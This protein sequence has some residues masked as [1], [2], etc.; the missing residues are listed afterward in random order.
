MDEQLPKN[1]VPFRPRGPQEPWLTR[2]GLAKHFAV[3]ERTVQRWQTEGLPYT[4][5]GRTIRYRLS[6]ANSWFEGQ[7]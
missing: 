5:R 6:E 7:S 1:T 4:G 3:S 2:K